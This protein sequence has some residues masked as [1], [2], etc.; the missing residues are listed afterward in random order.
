MFSRFERI[1]RE[2]NL[3]VSDVAK[4]TGISPSTFTDWK[5]GLYTPKQ[6]KLLK[7]SEF[8]EIPFEELAGISKPDAQPTY[9]PRIRD[10]IER[11]NNLPPAY[12]NAVYEALNYQEWLY[13]KNKAKKGV[14]NSTREA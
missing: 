6:D 4:A 1:L 5:K 8:L 10:F 9:S 7:I 2:R 3:K 12:Q 11:L 14:S 13:E